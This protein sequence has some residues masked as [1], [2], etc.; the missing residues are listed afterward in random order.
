M[1]TR[2]SEYHQLRFIIKVLAYLAG[3][4]IIVTLAFWSQEATI[5]RFGNVGWLP[6]LLGLFAL[7]GGLVAGAATVVT[8]LDRRGLRRHRVS[9][10]STIK[11]GQQVALSGRI[12][13]DGDPLQSPFS[14]KACAGFSYQVSG[15]GRSRG[16][17]NSQSRTQLCLAGFALAPAVLDCGTRQFRINAIADVDADL[18][19]TT[20]GGDWGQRA[21]DRIRASANSMPKSTAM[22]VRSALE[23]A[24]KQVRAPQSVDFFVA[25]TTGTDNTISVFEDILPVD[26]DVTLLA[27]YSEISDALDGRRLGGMKAFPGKMDERLAALDHD[28]HVGR[29]AALIFL[30]IGLALLCLVW[31]LP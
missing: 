6:W 7:L 3:M 13:V 17:E 12:R 14:E 1:S 19:S 15:Q 20:N 22:Q 9:P 2:V 30:T 5:A 28:F 4:V 10:N 29:K 16:S 11:D 8:W 31:W 21:F 27:A 25:S 18:R 23:A 26:C 24:R